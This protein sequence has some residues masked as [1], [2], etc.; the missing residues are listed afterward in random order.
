MPFDTLEDAIAIANDSDFG[1][2]PTV[3]TRD[4]HTAPSTTRAFDRE[5]QRQ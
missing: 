2:T 1:L 3:C 4:I 5:Q